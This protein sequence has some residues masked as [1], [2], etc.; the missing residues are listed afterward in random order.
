MAWYTLGV[1]MLFPILAA[2]LLIRLL[3]GLMKAA[4]K[5]EVWAYLSLP[6]GSA[7]PLTH[8]ENI[9]GRLEIADVTLNY[10]VVSRQHA[11]LIREE[12]DSWRAYDLGSKGGTAVNGAAVGAGGQAI[13]FGDVLSL[14]GVETV[15]LPVSDQET[16]RRQKRDEKPVSPWL[17]LL[18]LTLFQLL[19][20]FE[21]LRVV[22]EAYLVPLL[23]CFLLLMLAMWAYVLAMTGMGRTGFEPETIAFFLTTLSLSVTA[24][25]APQGLVKQTAAMGM[26]LVLFLVLGFFLRD[27][28][29]VRK[30]RWVMAAGAVGLLSLSLA[31]GSVKYGAANW[32]SLFGLS[33]QPSEVAKICYIFA[34]AATLERLFHRRNL[35]LFMVLT[36]LCLGCLA[37]MSDFG[38]AAIFF[39]TF[40][41]IAYLRSGDFATLALVCGGA[42]FALMILVSIKPYV[43][44]R[45]AAWGHAW[46]QASDGGFQQARTMSA[47]ASGG[48][49]GVG[50]G[51]GWLHQVPA[52]DTDLVFGML[53]EE[54][55][56]LIGLLAVAC[57]VALAVFAVRCGRASR[58]SFYTIAAC[59]ATGLL[60]VQTAL[61]VLG[62]VDILPL[63]G[64]TFPFVS[65]GGSSMLASWGLLAFVKAADTRSGASFAIR[66]Q[67]AHGAN[68][69][70]NVMQRKGGSHEAN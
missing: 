58:S 25:S 51:Q 40:L 10:P 55:G 23:G 22:E 36:G 17:S 57:V 18:L 38:T 6:N 30:V 68:W 48:L 33:F 2:L 5:G 56:L 39:A 54:W 3:R 1:R 19:A 7:Q 69:L 52:G 70:G 11:A 13:Q 64:V 67:K 43:L 4:P 20:L 61:N 50:P 47:A 31:V 15:L 26:G 63:T 41:V 29:R 46:E 21:L 44:R 28:G 59:A 27:L 35:G 66:A 14:S 8:W 12:G 60:V 53:C 45:F 16:R 42:V 9:V 34:G 24:S 65:N 32:I 37:L 49:I 62:A